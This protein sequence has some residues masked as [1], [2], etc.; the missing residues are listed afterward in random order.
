MA[1]HIVFKVG[2]VP[3]GGRRCVEIEGR[4]IVVFNLAGE[5][6]AL[7]DRCPHAGGRLSEGKLTGLL[8]SSAPGEYRYSRE[9]EVVRCPWHSWEFDIRT[10]KSQCDPRKIRVKNYP[11]TVE[12]GPSLTEGPYTAETFTVTVEDSYVVVEM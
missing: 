5:Y 3:E 4:R 11:V 9:G 6:F 10:G 12:G 8:Q 7:L 2:D 1:K